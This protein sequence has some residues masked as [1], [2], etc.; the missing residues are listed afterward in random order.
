MTASDS[1]TSKRAERTKVGRLIAEY[2]LTEV[3]AELERRW[4]KPSGERDGLRT[5][6]DV[7]NRRL[8]TRAMSDVGLN[9]LD[10]E[11]DNYYRLLTDDVGRSRKIEA[12]RRLEGAGIDVEELRTHFV[13]YQAIRTYLTEVRGASYDATDTQISVETTQNSLGRLVGRTTTV[14]KQ[15][16]TQ[17]RAADRI[18]LGPFHVQA[19]ITVYCEAC[20]TR[21]SLTELLARGGCNCDQ[22]QTPSSSLE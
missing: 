2:D 19:S 4:T 1:S 14:V 7:F 10:G 20:E 8:L 18:V 6:A 12:Q 16:L 22:E 5:L 9:P 15:K 17:L 13:T 21:H 11:A 3:G